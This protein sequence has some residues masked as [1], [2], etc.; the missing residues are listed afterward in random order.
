M[1]SAQILPYKLSN[2]CAV[3]LSENEI[4]VVGGAS[5]SDVPRNEVWIFD[6]QNGYARK[7]GPSLNNK[8]YK[9][10]VIPAAQ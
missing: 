5:S 7:Q 4:F 9:Y 3:K 8:R 1:Y 2:F 10:L 6:P